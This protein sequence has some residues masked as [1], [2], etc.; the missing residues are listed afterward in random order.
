MGSVLKNTPSYISPAKP[1][2]QGEGGTHRALRLASDGAGRELA[3]SSSSTTLAPLHPDRNMTT[4]E[5][6]EG[7]LWGKGEVGDS[8]GNDDK[9]SVGS[10]HHHWCTICQDRKMFSSCDGWKRHMKEHEYIYRCQI[11]ERPT[12]TYSRRVNLQRHLS[13]Y[14]GVSD[15]A[16]CILAQNGR[17]RD[18]KKAYA[19]GLCIQTFRILSDQLNHIDQ[20]HCGRG[21]DLSEWNLD[22]VIHGLLLQPNIQSSWRH[23]LGDTFSVTRDLTW[24]TSEAHSL[25]RRL[26]LNKEPADNLA[27][28]AIAQL[29]HAPLLPISGNYGRA[30]ASI[31][32]PSG[33]PFQR[34]ADITSDSSSDAESVESGVDSVASSKTSVVSDKFSLLA[35]DELVTCLLQNA[36]LGVIYKAALDSRHVGADRFE[37]NFRRILNHFSRDLKKEARN[38]GQTSAAVLVR[39]RSR[40]IANTL[41]QKLEGPRRSYRHDHILHGEDLTN[42]NVLKVEQY[43]RSMKGSLSSSSSD[44]PCI[45]DELQEELSSSDTDTLDNDLDDKLPELSH[46]KDFMFTSKAFLTLRTTFWELVDH[47]LR[48]NLARLTAEIECCRATPIDVSHEA[49]ESSSNRIKGVIED[50]TG[51]SW[52]WWPLKPRMGNIP[53]GYA[54]IRWYCVSTIICYIARANRPSLATRSGTKTCQYLLQSRSLKLPLML[55]LSSMQSKEMVKVRQLS[56][57]GPVTLQNRLQ[58]L[59]ADNRADTRVT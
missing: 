27:A 11:C 56:I 57:V 44:E 37:G 40:Y 31:T 48:L 55:Q 32:R 41:R 28:A 36:E 24:N 17:H 21:Q 18:M 5:R 9:G 50:F 3:D 6:K 33:E 47:S 2:E 14:H 7:I 45:R 1:W 53:A 30:K 58:C 12:R 4:V 39:R 26:E 13:S 16:A 22:K 23:L 25:I 35:A 52:D 29:T 8:N 54:R 59:T 42:L 38:I 20:E 49:I 34:V 19:C 15:D 10:S 51:V 46:I 43:L